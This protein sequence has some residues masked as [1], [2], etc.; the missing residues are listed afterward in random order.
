MSVICLL[1]TVD[2]GHSTTEAN[3]RLEPKHGESSADRRGKSFALGLVAVCCLA[4]HVLAVASPH[5]SA[6]GSLCS[7]SLHTFF[8]LQQ[9][10]GVCILSCSSLRKRLARLDSHSVF[11]FL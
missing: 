6:N 10:R 8:S 9:S 2:I 3:V 7:S 11:L 1:A 4:F 5:S